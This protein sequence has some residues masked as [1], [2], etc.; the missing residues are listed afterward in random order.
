[1]DDIKEQRELAMSMLERLGYQVAVVSSGEEAIEHLRHKKADLVVLD[2]M[3]E[4]GI[5]GFETYRRII[6]INPEQKAVIVSGFSETDRVG[7][8]QEIG[9]GSFVRKPYILEK[10][11]LAVRKELDRLQ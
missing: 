6:E 3:M 11:G 1:M 5:D 8:A 7:K 10:I 2:M 4:P 9:A